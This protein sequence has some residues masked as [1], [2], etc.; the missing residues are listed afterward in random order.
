[1]RRLEHLRE[2]A[3]DHLRDQRRTDPGAQ[4]SAS[5]PAVAREHGFPSWPRMKA[6]LD[7]SAAR[8][9]AIQFAY[10]SDLGYYEDRAYGLLA[11]AHDG[12]PGASRRSNA[13]A[14]RAR[15]PG[16]VVVARAHSFSSW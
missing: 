3:E 13:P 16:R 7:R 2:R 5:Q 4:L 11:S 9:D 14:P 10:H 8:A 15:R 12:T 1:M 6:H